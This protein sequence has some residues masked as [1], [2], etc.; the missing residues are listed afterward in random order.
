MKNRLSYFLSA[1]SLILL[2]CVS[3]SSCDKVKGPEPSPSTVPDS[4]G[5]LV[6]EKHPGA[7]DIV[8]KTVTENEL[9]EA[10]LTENGV[11]YY[12]GL[13]P[14]KIV[15]EQKLISPG[16]P[17][18]LERIFRNN[19]PISFENAVFSDYREDLINKITWETALPMYNVKL[20]AG[21]KEY[22]IYWIRPYRGGPGPEWVYMW[23]LIPY[24]KFFYTSNNSTAAE[25]PSVLASFAAKKGFTTGQFWA[26]VF[27]DNSAQLMVNNCCNN[28][29]INQ[30][31]QIL[32][33]TENMEA[34]TSLNDFPTPITQH[35]S[36][37][38]PNF[39]KFQLAGPENYKFSDSGT[40]GYSIRLK[41]MT[42]G[43]VAPAAE[44]KASFNKDFKMSRLEL[45]GT[46]AA[47]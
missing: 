24:A 14:E 36:S 34:I 35:I 2:A 20:T 16:L 7:S 9:W 39:Q 29:I 45:S 5:R 40:T 13:N 41:D 37:I 1:L 27:D 32:Q 22:L 11:Q 12:L 26:W 44:I 8:F 4:I 42:P 6:S 47:Q 30:E 31:G 18:S 3:L 28:Y 21:G 38:I 46:A 17:D 25:V 10:R 43:T 15:A 33:T 23:W 19:I